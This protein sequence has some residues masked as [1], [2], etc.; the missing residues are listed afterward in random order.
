MEYMG[1]IYYQKLFVFKISVHKLVELNKMSEI[2]Q[3][4]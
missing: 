1:V 2:F 3:N 4:E